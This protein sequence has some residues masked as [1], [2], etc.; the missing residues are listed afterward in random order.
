MGRIFRFLTFTSLAKFLGRI[1]LLEISFWGTPG[2]CI[3]RGKGLKSLFAVYFLNER[4]YFQL[5]Y[6]PEISI[7]VNKKYAIDIINAIGF[8]PIAYYFVK[9]KQNETVKCIFYGY[10]TYMV[11]LFFF[12]DVKKTTDEK[13]ITIEIPDE[14]KLIEKGS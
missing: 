12:T 2:F 13:R 14:K 4:I 10:L 8:I 9:H 7:R 1:T 5:L 6:L 3:L 11:V